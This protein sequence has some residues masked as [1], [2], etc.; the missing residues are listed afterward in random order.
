[1][2]IANHPLYCHQL[3]NGHRFPMEKY[4]LLPQQLLYE[5]L[6]DENDFFQP[7]LLT[8][9]WVEAIHTKEYLDKL[10]SLS[11]SKKE[12]RRT[13]FPLSR[14]LVEREYIIASGTVQNGID[15][16]HGGCSLNIAGGTHHAFA[17]HGEGFCLLND[18]AIA[19]NQLI[20]RFNAKRIAVID[21]DVHQGNGTAHLFQGHEAI[22]TFSMHGA[23][24]YP[25][26]KE[27][28]HLDIPL[29]DGTKDDEYLY[30]LERELDTLFQKQCPEVVFYQSG[31]DVLAS[32][33]LGRLALSM[34]G[35]K[36]RDSLVFEYCK[37]AEIGV[38][39][40]MGGGYSERISD[41]LNAHS[42]TFR[43]ARMVFG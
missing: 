9:T 1:M 41:I 12:E 14:Q 39:V 23:N 15:A 31:V 20:E 42:N 21:L 35:C 19:A 34:E 30:I 33:K 3:P 36:R 18:I 24:N 10:D 5:G 17:S 13:G 4:A 32:D 7:S 40:S 29:A 43:Q 8:K 22:Y 38:A 28:S 16:W 25:M 2:R 26:H 37:Q 11:L 6:A 27:R